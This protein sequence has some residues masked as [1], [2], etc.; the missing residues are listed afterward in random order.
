[1]PV[2]ALTFVV[3]PSLGSAKASARA[4]LIGGGLSRDLGEPVQVLVARDYGELEH[5]LNA[6]LA[7]LAWAPAMVCC[8]LPAVRKLFTVVRDETISYRSMLVARKGPKTSLATLGGQRV[9][10]VDPLSAGGYL[11][12]IA[13]LRQKGID[14]DT[15][16]SSQ[17]FTGSHRASIEAVLHGTADIA[18]VSG[19]DR[20]EEGIETFL[21]WYA[22]PLADQLTAI[23]MSEPCLNDALVIGPDVSDATCKRLV[24]KLIPTAPRAAARSRLLAAMEAERFLESTLDEYHHLSPLFSGEM[25]EKPRTVPPPPRADG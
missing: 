15:T 11:L 23:A 1:M 18:A 20:N 9:A 22:G 25:G 5:Q 16:F 10:W 4:E 7:Q 12:A 2:M 8:R 13:L 17:T 24:S 19:R 6:G 21:R 3:P 14:P